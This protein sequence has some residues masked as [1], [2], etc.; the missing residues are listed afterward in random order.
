MFVSR[1][2]RGRAFFGGSPMNLSAP[3]VP[4]FLISLILVVV[5]ALMV[6]GTVPTYGLPA[7]WVAIA[8]YAILFLGNVVRGM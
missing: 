7:F 8:G 2:P 5:A 6:L 4:V 3:T 1:R